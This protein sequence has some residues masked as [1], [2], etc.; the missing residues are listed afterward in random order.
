MIPYLV[1]KEDPP[2]RFTPESDHQR[3][4]T[5]GRFDIPSYGKGMSASAMADYVDEYQYGIEVGMRSKKG[6]SKSSRSGPCRHR[7][8]GGKTYQ[9]AGRSKLSK[10]QKYV[11]EQRDKKRAKEDRAKRRSKAIVRRPRKTEM[12]A[13]W[14]DTP[15]DHPFWNNGDQYYTWTKKFWDQS[16]RPD[17]EIQYASRWR[18]TDLDQDRCDWRP[19][20]GFMTVTRT[21]VV[22][23][24]K[25][26][27]FARMSLLEMIDTLPV[28]K[29]NYIIEGND[30]AVII[31]PDPVRYRRIE[32]MV[33]YQK[34]PVYDN[35]WDSDSDSDD[36]SYANRYVSCCDFGMCSECR[37]DRDHYAHESMCRR[38]REQQTKNRRLY[39]EEIDDV[40]NYYESYGPGRS[41]GRRYGYDSDEDR[42]GRDRYDSD[43][44]SE[45]GNDDIDCWCIYCTSTKGCHGGSVVGMYGLA[46]RCE[47]GNCWCA[48]R[49]R[50]Q[51]VTPS[52]P[53]D[54][55]KVVE[56]ESEDDD[57][58]YYYWK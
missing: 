3:L 31:E 57:D 19:S 6:K 46:E 7:N 16:E 50:G 56:V 10:Q 37:A 2:C 15:V 42:Y 34:A 14:E 32:R 8:R 49:L 47:I 36:S 55:K 12:A 58:P 22:P 35:S 28:K 39:R 53:P 1:H 41:R 20:L 21:E 40:S 18:N 33:Q 17:T 23:E 43:A 48:G 26:P 11:R 38:L 45:E 27:D 52:K 5:M 29:R 24:P 25:M 44:V 9:A 30:T 4:F 54:G 13:R 51:T